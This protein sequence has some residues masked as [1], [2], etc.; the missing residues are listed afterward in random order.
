M[1]VF[2]VFGV[3]VFPTVMITGSKSGFGVFEGVGSTVVLTGVGSGF[4]G[5]GVGVGSVLTSGLFC[6]VDQF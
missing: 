1:S 3:S 4:S 6:G 5:E 2:S